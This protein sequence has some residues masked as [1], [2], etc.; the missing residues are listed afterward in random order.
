MLN[1]VSATKKRGLHGTAYAL[2]RLPISTT[3]SDIAMEYKYSKESLPKVKRKIL[4]R[5]SFELVVTLGLVFAYFYSIPWYL[6]LLPSVVIALFFVGNIWGLKNIEKHR[7]E[8]KIVQSEG[9][10]TIFLYGIEKPQF[11]PWSAMKIT[12]EKVSKGT[13]T[14][15]TVDTGGRY[16]KKWTFTDDIEPFSNFHKEMCEHVRA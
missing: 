8:M 15:F 9:G 3:L 4:I 2:L 14:S 7:N 11:V 6:T 5:G 10:L 1:F 12:E 13:L 16:F